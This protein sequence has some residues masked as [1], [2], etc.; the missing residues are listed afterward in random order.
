MR[1]PELF[2]WFHE[3]D[4]SQLLEVAMLACSRE[5]GGRLTAAPTLKVIELELDA[6]VTRPASILVIEDDPD[7][8]WEEYLRVH[9]WTNS[10]P[11][12]MKRLG[13]SP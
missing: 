1:G 4:A 9:G 2:G 5:H 7:G 6:G 3:G 10:L 12:L 13:P 11:E 8:W